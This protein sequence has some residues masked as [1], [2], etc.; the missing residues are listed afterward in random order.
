MNIEEL[1]RKVRN[2]ELLAAHAGSMTY[3]QRAALRE[4]VAELHDAISPSRTMTKYALGGAA[5]GAVL[6]VL[7]L[8]S[9]GA[10]GALW[11]AVRAHGSE[12]SDARRRLAQLLEVLS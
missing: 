6:P 10:A 2:Y 5:A 4:E 12:V 7:G 3:E 11:G 9:G 8:L 1:T